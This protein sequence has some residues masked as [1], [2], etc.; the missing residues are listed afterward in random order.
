MKATKFGTNMTLPAFC[1]TLNTWWETSTLR[2]TMDM[3]HEMSDLRSLGVVFLRRTGSQLAELKPCS[4]GLFVKRV[5]ALS[6]GAFYICAIRIW[7]AWTPQF[8]AMI[9]LRTPFHIDKSRK[10][11]I[12][13]FHMFH[14]FWCINSQIFFLLR[15]TENP[16]GQLQWPEECQLTLR[17]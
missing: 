5:G 7:L 2:A 11:E 1:S 13:W 3:Y 15:A 6:F 9:N 4:T 8:L 12:H 10:R 16:N 14:I 17:S